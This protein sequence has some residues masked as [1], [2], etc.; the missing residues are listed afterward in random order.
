MKSL[1]RAY[2]PFFYGALIPFGFAPFSYA[3]VIWIAL[4]CFYLYLEH[5][6][7][8]DFKSG[9]LFGIGL[10]LVGTSWIYHS[11]HEY[12]HLQ[13]LFSAIITFL[14]ILY[15]AFFY[16]VFSLA[17]QRLKSGLH[18]SL[19]PLLF[20]SCWCLAEYFRAHC[21]G[22]FPWLILGFSAVG[23]PLAPLL[24]WFG[25]YAPDFVI[26]L[27]MG[28]FA[29]AIS[30][31]GFKRLYGII[32]IMLFGLPACFHLPTPQAYK[33]GVFVHI[34]QGNVKTQDKWDE[35]FFWQA[36]H[37][38]MKAIV[39]NLAP[40]K[41]II[42]PEAAI[43]V[44][45]S[46]VHDELQQLHQLAKKHKS[47]ILLGIPKS[48]D[49][50]NDFYNSMLG[51]GLAQGQ[52]YKQQ[53]VPFGEYIPHLLLPIIERLGFPVVNMIQ[54]DPHQESMKVFGQN[55]VSLICYELAYPEHLRHQLP[56]GEWIVSMSDD[57]W[58]G[59]S[60]ALYQHLQMAQAFSLMSHRDQVFVNNN[61]L[62]SIINAQGKIIA[63]LPAWKTQQLQGQITPHQQTTPWMKWGDGP[64][65]L[66]CIFIIL[67]FILEKFG[68]YLSKTIAAQLKRLYP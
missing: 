59:H 4:L 11:I 13:P 38:Y 51:L 24:P 27:A 39:K 25:I 46:Y 1:F 6:P 43:T 30:N 16:G 35:Q 64:I 56:Q 10:N 52:Y 15:V 5:H 63:K 14:F 47:A 37:Y 68:I 57:G 7:F 31:T 54:G 53:L 28:Y 58:F 33:Q 42:L 62:S 41:L 34:I 26:A 20:A 45:Q 17:Y 61:G 3:F 8:L 66:C 49:N 9:Y 32:G 12:G 21:F 22:G 19:R 55:I 36:T 44:P 23:T 29:I 60:F 2:Q 50:E 65:L 18:E 48:S 67:L 40:Q